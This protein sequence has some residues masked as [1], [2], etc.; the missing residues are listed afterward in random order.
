MLKKILTSV[1]AAAL[2]TVPLTSQEA[3]TDQQTQPKPAPS[4]TVPAPRPPDPGQPVN[5]KLELTITDQVGPGEPSK[6]VVTMIVADRQNGFIRSKGYQ[7]LPEGLMREITINMDARPVIVK[8][9]SIRVDLGLE[10]NPTAPTDAAAA[11][12]DAGRSNLNQRIAF[13][14]EP[15]K[16]LI[17]SQAADPASDRKITVELRATI[18]K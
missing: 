4:E 8:E 2:L 16:P 12:R 5:V 17:V 1:A 14:V 6:K 3:R 11:A 10:Y 18:L 13:I 15:G 7:R 9:T